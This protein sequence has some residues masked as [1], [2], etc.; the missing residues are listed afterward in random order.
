[1]MLLRVHDMKTCNC[2]LLLLFCKVMEFI[3]YLICNRFYDIL[4][5]CEIFYFTDI[6]FDTELSYV[7]KKLYIK[8]YI[9][10]CLLFFVFVN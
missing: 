10:G 8:Y 3:N 5:F 4:Y 6:I 1:M 9:K 7:K 2:F